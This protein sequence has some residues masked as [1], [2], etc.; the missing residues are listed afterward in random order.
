MVSRAMRADR[1]GIDRSSFLE[2][3]SDEV[4]ILTAVRALHEASSP[5]LQATMRN[6]VDVVASAL[7]C[8]LVALHLPSR[9]RIETVTRDWPGG[10]EAPTSVMGALV[11]LELDMDLLPYFVQDATEAPLPEPLGPGSGITSYAAVGIGSPVSAVLLACRASGRPFTYL[12]R[13]MLFEMAGAADRVL[14][15]SLQLG[16]QQREL[17]RLNRESRR[18]LHSGLPSGLAWDEVLAD[19]DKRLCR[20]P[21]A[22]SVLV[23]LL[24]AVSDARYRGDE[25]VGGE[26]LR[27]IA[28][29]VEGATRET[30]H[31]ARTGEERI[32][33]LLRDA[34]EDGCLEAISRIERRLIRH[35]GI[36][37]RPLSVTVGHAGCPP[38]AALD[39][40]QFLAAQRAEAR[41]LAAE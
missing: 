10:D 8:E 31:V 1:A 26:M 40:A 12:D 14:D 33:V 18:D 28:M 9:E 13:R 15:S 38:F 20:V 2:S 21:G 7:S 17:D 22:A 5:D 34:D 6:V 35:P 29:I 19:E 36:D 32:S 3:A 39:D 37:G 41:R 4:V 27:A 25:E 16:D 23:V 30:D 24:D 11:R